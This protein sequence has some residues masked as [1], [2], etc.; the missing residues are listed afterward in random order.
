MLV[1]ERLLVPPQTDTGVVFAAQGSDTGCVTFRIVGLFG[2]GVR[3]AADA[4]IGVHDTFGE[5]LGGGEDHRIV[6]AT[7][8]S[9][10]LAAV[11][12]EGQPFL[13]ADLFQFLLEV[14]GFFPG[15]GDGGRGIGVGAA[16]IVLEGGG[17]G[18]AVTDVGGGAFHVPFFEGELDTLLVE[19]LGGTTHVPASQ[20][21]FGAEEGH[22]GGVQPGDL[23]KGGVGSGHLAGGVL[24]AGPGGRADARAHAVEL[25]VGGRFGIG[26]AA[27][28]VVSVQIHF[29]RGAQLGV[30]VVEVHVDFVD[31][32]MVHAAHDGIPVVGL[33]HAEGA[34]DGLF[35]LGA[36]QLGVGVADAHGQA[37]TQASSFTHTSFS[38]TILSFTIIS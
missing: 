12:E 18:R 30:G 28:V 38:T 37:Q 3:D 2:D 33:D 1:V 17:H 31:G 21:A 27:G 26:E 4:F 8:F 22:F 29:Q 15:D 35:C 14:V 24:V 11:G 23:I 6:Q 36:G 32:M 25:A 13:G 20:G 16:H 9:P 19:F 7:V 10:G 5:V 34:G